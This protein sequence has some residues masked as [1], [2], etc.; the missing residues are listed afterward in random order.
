M[1][2]ELT[3][4]KIDK[5]DN[6]S[7][8]KKDKTEQNPIADEGQKKK[9]KEK[10]IILHSSSVKAVWLKKTIESIYYVPKAV[11]LSQPFNKP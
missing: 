10:I 8:V 5:I 6:V 4:T 3:M 2:T 9:K 7:P 11:M 1:D